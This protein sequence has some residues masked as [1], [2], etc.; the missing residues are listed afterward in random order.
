MKTTLI[1][2]LVFFLCV[3]TNSYAQT[4]KAISNSD[5]LKQTN[6]LDDQTKILGQV[7]DLMGAGAD[8][9]V[10]N[11]TNYLEFIDNMDI[12]DEM[13]QTL[14]DQHE[15]IDLGNDPTKKEELK[16]KISEM[17]DKGVMDA[18]IE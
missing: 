14:R 8:N 5:S 6:L 12:S 4:T 7:F 11:A 1:L 3:I 2:I 18:Q 10:G 9:P 17:L 16:I 15:I 13:K